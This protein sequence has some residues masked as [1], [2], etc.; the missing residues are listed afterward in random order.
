MLLIKTVQVLGHFFAGGLRTVWEL[1]APTRGLEARNLVRRIFGK[2]RRAHENATN[3]HGEKDR[4]GDKMRTK[5]KRAARE[6]ITTGYW[7]IRSGASPAASALAASSPTVCRRVGVAAKYY[8]ATIIIT[9]ARG[10]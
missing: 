6:T 3:T 7:R 4:M 10:K 8:S 5:R 1:L 9:S 2:K